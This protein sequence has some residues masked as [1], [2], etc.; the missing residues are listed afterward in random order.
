MVSLSDWFAA[1]FPIDSIA[2]VSSDLLAVFC[3]SDAI[4]VFVASTPSMH[5]S[6]ALQSLRPWPA[7]MA[8]IWR[9]V[10]QTW[11][12]W[13]QP[14]RRPGRLPLTR[15]HE[16]GPRADDAPA[17]WRRRARARGRFRAPSE[18]A[19]SWQPSGGSRRA[20]GDASVGAFRSPRGA[21][22]AVALLVCLHPG[23]D[24]CNAASSSPS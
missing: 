3:S 15:E 11:P 8:S 22:G 12:F 13:P 6:P 19:A 14:R 2:E 20:P 4:A 5:F 16:W 17:P 9:N 21:R 24:I 10:R 23:T 7:A 18:A 1:H